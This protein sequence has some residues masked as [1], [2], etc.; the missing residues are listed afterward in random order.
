MKN[1][2]MTYTNKNIRQNTLTCV[3][4]IF[5]SGPHNPVPNQAQANEALNISRM[6]L[7]NVLLF[8]GTNTP[9][10]VLLCSTWRHENYEKSMNFEIIFKVTT[11]LHI[12]GHSLRFYL[13]CLVSQTFWKSTKSLLCC[14]RYVI[15]F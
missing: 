12:L 4:Y 13:Y 3:I 7:Y 15:H 9:H 6:L 8:L 10:I 5:L 2:N 14:F 11:F 1:M